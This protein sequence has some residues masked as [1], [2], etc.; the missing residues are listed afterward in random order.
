[1]GKT[2]M[3][4]VIYLHLSWLFYVIK[5]EVNSLKATAVLRKFIQFIT[6][7]LGITFLTF[8]LTYLAPGDPATAM[9]ETAGIVPSTEQIDE[10][11]K[12]MG[13]DRP[14]IQQYISWLTDCLHGD[15]GTSF[16]RNA[17]VADIMQS[18]IAPTM[19]LTL[20]SLLL[21]II[22]SLPLGI[23]SAIYKNKISD[24]I[25]R[26]L[27]FMGIS[28]PGFWVGLMLQY[29][30]AVK[31]NVF[32]VI[33]SGDGFQKMILPSITLAIS[34]SAK[35]T[36]QI[37]TAV[38]EELSQDYVIGAKARG[39]SY[40]QILIRHILPNSIL[41]LITLLGLSF[42]SLL[43]GAAVVEIIFSYPGMGQLAVSAV[44][45]RDYPLIQGFVLWIA[46]IYM[47]VNF[48]VDISYNILDPRIRKSR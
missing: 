45:Y 43:G 39:I 48:I 14:F 19:R 6:V 13:L 23:I 44:S 10:A 42:G 8:L 15:F 28:M 35:Y 47:L 11:R 30:F 1:M 46:V 4:A 3:I 31:L 38:L 27:N 18:R 29:I 26:F 40:R 17:P 16:S 22:I 34:M 2:A 24:Y 36:R 20:S 37:R 33:S 41:P 7:L 21:M 25:I 5:K 12:T 32:P 9:F